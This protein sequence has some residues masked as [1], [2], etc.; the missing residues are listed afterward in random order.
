MM[1]WLMLAWEK[2]NPD[3]LASSEKQFYLL[4]IINKH[5]NEAQSVLC[6]IISVLNNHKEK[7]IFFSLKFTFDK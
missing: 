6:K 4:W 2:L 7:K 5:S 1:V 3:I